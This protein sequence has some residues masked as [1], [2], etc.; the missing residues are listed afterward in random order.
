[1]ERGPEGANGHVTS[2]TGSGR[3]GALVLWCLAR[4]ST[5]AAKQQSITILYDYIALI[6][7]RPYA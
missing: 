6:V 1:M 7:I 5:K 4:R 3:T 2:Q